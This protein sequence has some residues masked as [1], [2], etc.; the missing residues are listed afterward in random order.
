MP[1]YVYG[2]DQ[3]KDHP[4]QEVTHKM[5]DNPSIKCGEC[6]SKMH[7]VP[8]SMRFYMGAVDGVLIPW[9]EENY[10]RMRA[11]KK[12]RKAPH[13]NK[14]KV[15]RPGAGVPQKDFHTRRYKL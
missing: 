2:C 15:T 14:D 3:D 4:R 10:N 5:S 8:Q 1:T 7:R 11:R 6:G 13:F 12:G 9:M